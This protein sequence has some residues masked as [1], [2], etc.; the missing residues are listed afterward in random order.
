MP[1]QS[2]AP[3]SRVHIRTV[4]T[5]FEGTIALGGSVR[6]KEFINRPSPTLTLTDARLCIAPVGVIRPF[7]AV[8]AVTLYK[9]HILYATLVQEV[10]GSREKVYERDVLA[11]RLRREDFLFQLDGGI[12]VTG[13]VVGGDHSIA[14]A[15]GNFLAVSHPNVT[16]LRGE[17]VLSGVSFVLINLGHVEYYRALS[18]EAPSVTLP[19]ESAAEE[20]LE[21][22][23]PDFQDQFIRIDKVDLKTPP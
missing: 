3:E 10:S 21:P 20:A 22:E 2:P 13:E 12:L 5:T 18:G 15:R 8:Q 17:N 9:A 19:A 11:A 14:F 4:N 6:L 23:F 1:I 16:N 7:Q